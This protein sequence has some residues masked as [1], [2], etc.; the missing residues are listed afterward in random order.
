MKSNADY[1]NK[2]AAQWQVDDRYQ[3]WRR[4]SD[5]VHT[6]FL[7]PR[8]PASPVGCLLKTDMFDESCSDG[9]ASLLRRHTRMFL[10][11]DLSIV[12]LGAARS[13]QHGAQFVAADVRSLPLAD[14]SCDYIVSNST[15]DHFADRNDIAASIAELARVLR[16]GGEL[17]LTLDNP[18]NPLVGLRNALPFKLLNRLGI[19]PCF[20][21]ATCGGRALRSQAAA[22]KLTVLETA[23]FL[24]CPR[25][26]CVAVAR[27]LNKRGPKTQA[28][29]VSWMSRW[30][31]LGRL[32]SRFL[33]ANYV[34]IRAVKAPHGT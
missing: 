19:V 4:V 34:A 18:A 8:L 9:L 20:V 31:W 30:E 7:V 15:L 12:V 23:Y 11:M 22:A 32:P 24:H 13:R 1:W 17:L 26:A 16:P 3:L 21:G 2:T 5:A 33:T 14:E 28:R 27:L 6:E 29:F 10:G 25:V